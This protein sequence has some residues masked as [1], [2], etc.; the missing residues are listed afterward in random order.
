VLD[1]EPD[2]GVS[3]I[4]APGAGTDNNGVGKGA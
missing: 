1:G 3:G 4:D 2:P